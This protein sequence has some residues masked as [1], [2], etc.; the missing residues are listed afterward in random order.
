MASASWRRAASGTR[1][2]GGDGLVEGPGPMGGALAGRRVPAVDGV[3][4]MAAGGVEDA[5]DAEVAFG[6][7]AGADVGGLVGHA[8]VEGG[9]VGVG[10]DGD[11]G[12]AHFAERADDADGDL[13]AIGDQDL[14]EHADGIVAGRGG[15]GRGGASGLAG[16]VLTRRRGGAEEEAEKTVERVKTWER[17]VSGDSGA[18]RRGVRRNRRLAKHGAGR[19]LGLTYEYLRSKFFVYGGNAASTDRCGVGNSD[20]ALEPRAGYGAPGTR[21]RLRTQAHAVHHG[22]QD[23]TDHGGERAGA[24]RREAAGAHLPGRAAAGMDAAATGGRLAP[25]GV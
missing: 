17:G 22:A 10:E 9:A 14:A 6:G 13:A 8:D 1:S 4:V 24:P 11:A 16:W 7:G 21:L 12:D 3:G 23:V 5:V 15:G 2:V 25:A 20:R 18:S 19:I